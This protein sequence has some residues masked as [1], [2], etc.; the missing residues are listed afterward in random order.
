M[1][2]LAHAKPIVASDLPPLRELAEASGAMLLVPN[3]PVA[4]AEAILRLRTD[5]TL[6][7]QLSDAA[8]QFAQSCTVTEAAKQHFAL[9]Q[10]VS[11]RG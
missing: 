5:E 10:Q 11:R 8:R 2:A 4:W 7:Q 3:E 9:Y 6:R 1:R